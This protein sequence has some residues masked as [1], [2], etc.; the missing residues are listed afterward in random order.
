LSDACGPVIESVAVS[1]VESLVV[2]RVAEVYVVVFFS[3]T[4]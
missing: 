3:S 4:L 2:A 1:L